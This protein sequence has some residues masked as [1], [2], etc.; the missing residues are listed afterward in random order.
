MKNIRDILDL[1]HK[2]S[3]RLGLLLLSTLFII[4][5]SALVYASMIY[6]KAKCER[7]CTNQCLRQLRKG[8]TGGTAS[9]SSAS[10]G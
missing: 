1:K 2:K 6:E 9:E 3:L 4:S 8:S 7:I 5:T 10:S